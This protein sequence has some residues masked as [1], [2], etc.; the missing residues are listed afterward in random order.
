MKSFSILTR[1]DGA[2]TQ[3]YTWTLL[4]LL[5]FQYPHSD[6]R[7]QDPMPSWPTWPTAVSVSS[8]GSTAPRP[9]VFRTQ[10]GCQNDLK[11]PSAAS[12]A[13]SPHR[14]RRFLAPN[15]TSPA[16]RPQM[17]ACSQTRLIC[18]VLPS[19]T[20]DPA[21]AAAPAA[22]DTGPLR[23]ASGRDHSA[24]SPTPSPPTSLNRAPQRPRARPAAPTPAGH[25]ALVG[26]RP[27]YP[28]RQAP[29]APGPPSIPAWRPR[30]TRTRARNSYSRMP[31]APLRIPQPPLPCART[32]TPPADLRRPP[33]N[34]RSQCQRGQRASPLR[35]TRIVRR[36][37][38]PVRCRRQN[39]LP[40]LPSRPWVPCPARERYRASRR[41][42]P[43][44]PTS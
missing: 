9:K 8:L 5:R 42:P 15:C 13:F 37:R 24:V 6:R 20:T 10:R 29:W 14:P 16:R 19:I 31:A 33:H 17:P 2:K 41:W 32:A 26:P 1:I 39:P 25:P 36:G 44:R 22:T 43:T 3:Q 12:P 28:S 35:P 27:P 34:P 38:R 4:T 23:T 40:S 21:P 7:R 18:D 11:P 30:S